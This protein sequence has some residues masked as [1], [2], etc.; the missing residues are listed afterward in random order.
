MIPDSSLEQPT[1]DE[2]G[3][4][5]NT[6]V[7]APCR[8]AAPDEAPAANGFS[9]VAQAISRRTTDLLA[10]GLVLAAGMSFGRQVLQWWHVADPA[11]ASAS[12]APGLPSPLWGEHGQPVALEFGETPF[13][14][15]RQAWEG[16]QEQAIAALAANCRE[17]TERA[18][19]RGSEWTAEQAAAGD[20]LLQQIDR[21][22]LQ[23]FEEERGRWR[24]FQIDQP[25]PIIVG[26]RDD[27]AVLS[28]RKSPEKGH[29]A[30][31]AH[32]VCW[33]MAL[34]QGKAAW[35]LYTF[36]VAPALPGGSLSGELPPLPAGA[37][38]L[39]SLR[40]DAGGA[41]VG[42]S[43]YGSPEAWRQSF[44]DW[45]ETHHWKSTGWKGSGAN[46][47]AQFSRSDAAGGSIVVQFGSS[48]GTGLTGI[49]NLISTG[50]P[51]VV[52]GGK[53]P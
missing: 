38:R 13:S 30:R 10:I 14:L 3:T 24:L 46:W 8:Q 5:S 27:A 48:G 22:R 37:R 28:K 11:E 1:A 47:S 9:G 34:R 33:G 21:S 19:V 41:L 4:L 31:S 52:D 43:G 45:F 36:R 6:Q 20:V 16:T 32:V 35:T 49:L 17:F 7:A 18:Q 26:V 39:M 50:G 44:D 15:T 40:E 53:H 29:P 23:P 51:P 42:F 2:D 12:G 25:L